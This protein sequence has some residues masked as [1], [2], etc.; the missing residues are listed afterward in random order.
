MTL[1]PFVLMPALPFALT[2]L[3]PPLNLPPQSTYT[4]QLSPFILQGL[5]N[6]SPLVSSHKTV[7]L[8][9]G[10]ATSLLLALHLLLFEFIS[11]DKVR[12]VENH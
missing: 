1:Y 5:T 7:F 4:Q 12:T 9:P 11:S 3:F 2:V 10:S 6:Q 8:G